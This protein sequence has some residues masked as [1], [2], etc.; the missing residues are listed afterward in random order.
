VLAGRHPAEVKKQR[1]TR[2]PLLLLLLLPLL[3]LIIIGA[4]FGRHQQGGIVA[5]GKC[6][7]AGLQRQHRQRLTVPACAPQPDGA[8]KC[9]AG[10]ETAAA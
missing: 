3:L 8:V 5:R 1:P 6:Y 9:A 10:E 7:T 4:G 2:R